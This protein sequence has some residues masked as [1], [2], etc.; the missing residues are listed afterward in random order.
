MKQKIFFI[1]IIL[2][3]I[4]FVINI[5]AKKH[6]DAVYFEEGVNKYLEGD[7]DGAISDFKKSLDYNSDNLDSKTALLKIY[8]E[9]GR[10]YY[11]N[12]DYQKALKDFNEANTIS[13]DNQTIVDLIKNSKQQLLDNEEHIVQEVSPNDI[14]KIKQAIGLDD[15]M[16]S[17][18][19]SLKEFQARDE[20]LLKALEEQKSGVLEL[21]KLIFFVIVG[22]IVAFFL[23]IIIVV[24]FIKKVPQSS[25]IDD[26]KLDDILNKMKQGDGVDFSEK[27]WTGVKFKKDISINTLKQ[28]LNSNNFNRRVEAFNLIFLYDKEMAFNLIR[29]KLEKGTN[30]DKAVMY[31]VL[32]KVQTIQAL[33]LLLEFSS[34]AYLKGHLKHSIKNAL[35]QYLNLKF[36]T[37]KHKDVIN[38]I[39]NQ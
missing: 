34:D 10:Y 26:K 25:S 33:L 16:Q 22:G 19:K 18:M 39:I 27:D 2:F 6:I 29:E 4:F 13:P 12:R 37:Q 31:A 8:M 24:F 11:N 20:N 38:R 17:F 28:A 36:L 14:E 15:S 30:S 21:K 5:E 7:F 32:G 35:K 23:F 9:R 1:F 3:S